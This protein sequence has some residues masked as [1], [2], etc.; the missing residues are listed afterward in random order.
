MGLKTCYSNFRPLLAPV[1]LVSHTLAFRTGSFASWRR[2]RDPDRPVSPWCLVAVATASAPDTSSC[3]WWDG[4]AGEWGLRRQGRRWMRR[5]CRQTWW[6][7]CANEIITKNMQIIHYFQFSYSWID[8][9]SEFNK[10]FIHSSIWQYNHSI[11]QNVVHCFNV[12][13]TK[14]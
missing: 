10:S 9:F 6:K 3:G 1:V 5:E 4:T 2:S 13:F 14:S 8:K 12:N 11:F 7:T